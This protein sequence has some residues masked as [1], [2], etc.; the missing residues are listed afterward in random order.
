MSIKLQLAFDVIT[1]DKAILVLEELEGLIDIVEVGTPFIVEGGMKP[2]K[3]IRKRFPDQTILA[4]V[5]I[6]DGAKIEA[7]SAFEAGADIVTV[8]AL[9]ETQTI[10]DTV[11]TARAY[12][13]KVLVDMLA[14]KDIP[15]KTRELETI[16]VDY[17]CV[18]NAFDIQSQGK[19]PL[20]ELL[21]LKQHIKTA[22]AAVAGGIKLQTLPGIV[23]AEPDIII[24]GGAITNAADMRSTVKKMRKIMEAGGCF[25]C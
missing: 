17:I 23:E 3:E 24:V 14:V 1:T 15:T 12:Q 21:I 4:D 6:A 2:V 7:K 10:M 11:E 22:K 19:N 25:R 20:D 9:A 5:K 18:H 13:K 16:G 8:L